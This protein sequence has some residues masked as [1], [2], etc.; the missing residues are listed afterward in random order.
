[1]S[2]EFDFL[3]IKWPKMAALAA[4]ASRLVEI[5][6]SSAIASMRTFCEW[7]SDI[8]L[9]MYKVQVMPGAT[10]MEKLEALQAT[11]RVPAEIL[12][13]F[14]NI[15]TAG[16][17]AVHRALGDAETARSSLLETKDIGQ[18]LFRESDSHVRPRDP[19]PIRRVPLE[20]LYPEENAGHSRSMLGA[21]VGGHVRP[22]QLFRQ[23]GPQMVIGAG[24]LL[25]IGIIILI[26]LLASRCSNPSERIPNDSVGPT[27]IV[28]QTGTPE[29]DITPTVAPTATPQ[30]Y[31]LFET[32]TPSSDFTGLFL[33]KWQSG[34]HTGNFQI[35]NKLYDHGIGMFVPSRMISEERGSL[36]ATWALL[37]NY[38]SLVFDLGADPNWDYGQNNG[39]YQIKIFCD[40]SSVPAYDSGLHDY[41][42]TQE[43]VIVDI[44]GCNSLKIVITEKKGSAGTL[45]IVLG[46]ARLYENP[47]AESTDAPG[48]TG[49]PGPTSTPGAT[50]TPGPTSTPGTN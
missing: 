50:G 44:R 30:P 23:Y 20:G 22:G 17:D 13:K 32:L 6:P 12:Q 11:G 25:V 49:T 34:T 43:N 26:V 18:W 48:A 15:R 2:S 10:Q 27:G 38:S 4:D 21:G 36:S 7:A 45:N 14:H 9:D 41:Q 24:V 46:D 35:G 1:M 8:A 39:L 47:V 28:A 3:R 37:G 16:N 42:F 40:S 33:E 31:I 5:S 19:S 29:P